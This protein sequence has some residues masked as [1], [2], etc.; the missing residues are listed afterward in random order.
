[1]FQAL[2]SRRV[3]SPGCPS[4]PPPSFQR[5]ALPGAT[6]CKQ[7]LKRLKGELLRHFC[8]KTGK[9]GVWDT[10]ITSGFSKNVPKQQKRGFGTRAAGMIMIENVPKQQKRD[11]GTRAEGMIMIK[12]VPKP[13]KQ[14]VW[15]ISIQKRRSLECP[16]IYELRLLGHFLKNRRPNLCPKSV[17]NALWDKMLKSV[18][19]R[20]VPK[21]GKAG[22][23]ANSRHLAPTGRSW[24]CHDSES[25]LG[26]LIAFSVKI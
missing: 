7:R 24:K 1:M 17:K 12:N 23:G 22:F 4:H 3:L 9:S 10:F 15:D 25:R 11:S 6:R 26:K 13:L 19:E 14:G 16:K 21:Q 18:V 8:P 20:N 5:R 2:V